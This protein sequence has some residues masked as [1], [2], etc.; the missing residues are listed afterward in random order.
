VEV[1]RETGRIDNITA[2]QEL[3]QEDDQV[4]AEGETTEDENEQWDLEADQ[5]SRR[6]SVP[7]DPESGSSHRLGGSQA[8]K[9]PGGTARGA[10]GIGEG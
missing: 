2:V 9:P 1:S 7:R 5:S 3:S 4:G 8:R 10:R 6:A